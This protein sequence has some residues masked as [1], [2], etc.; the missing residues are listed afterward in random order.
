MESFIDDDIGYLRWLAAHRDGFVLTAER[1]PTPAYLMPHRTTCHTISGTPA[2]GSRWTGDYIKFCGG[3][4]ELEAFAC[5]N[6]GGQA[7]ACGLCR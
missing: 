7:H 3:R 1:K 6:V 4:H 2:C 5:S